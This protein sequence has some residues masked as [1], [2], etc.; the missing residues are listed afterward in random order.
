MPTHVFDIWTCLECSFQCQRVGWCWC[1]ASHWNVDIVII[2]HLGWMKELL[3]WTYR[4]SFLACLWLVW[5]CCMCQYSRALY[6]FYIVII[7]KRFYCDATLCVWLYKEYMFVVVEPIKL[8]LTSRPR[9]GMYSLFLKLQ[10][11]CKFLKIS[12]KLILSISPSASDALHL[13]RHEI[14]V[15]LWQAII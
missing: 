11:P 2:R 7:S 9:S 3:Q 12:R 14:L 15:I 5:Q 13:P 8:P 1:L 10:L 6:L 4:H